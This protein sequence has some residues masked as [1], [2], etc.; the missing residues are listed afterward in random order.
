MSHWI[1]V[2]IWQYELAYSVCYDNYIAM[3]YIMGI[4]IQQAPVKMPF[5]VIKIQKINILCALAGY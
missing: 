4:K 1:Q 5:F 2:K 3:E